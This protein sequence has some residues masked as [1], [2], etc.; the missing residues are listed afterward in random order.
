M[1]NYYTPDLIISSHFSESRLSELLFV[2]I[3][4]PNGTLFLES[5]VEIAQKIKN[6]YDSLENKNADKRSIILN[7]SELPVGEWVFNQIKNKYDSYCLNRKG[8]KKG[9]KS[10]NAG[11]IFCMHDERTDRNTLNCPVNLSHLQQE[12]LLCESIY[13]LSGGKLN[14]HHV[15]EKYRNKFLAFKFTKEYENLSFICVVG[16]ESNIDN[17][18]IILNEDWLKNSDNILAKHVKK[19][20]VGN[21]N[22]LFE[23]NLKQPLIEL[24]V[25]SKVIDDNNPY[26]YPYGNVE[27]QGGEYQGIKLTPIKQ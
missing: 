24:E 8:K 3:N 6:A 16:R 22:V 19:F 9:G 5:E 21:G 20:P 17:D 2:Q 11:L 27:Y 7:P 23:N 1:K 4:E 14:Y 26:V 15:R 18:Y 12:V 25:E 10:K 13:K